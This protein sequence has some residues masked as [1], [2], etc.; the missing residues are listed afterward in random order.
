MA[1]Y[2]EYI[3]KALRILKYQNLIENGQ[4][5]EL[6]GRGENNTDGSENAQQERPSA[7]S[8]PPAKKRRSEEPFTSREIAY[9]DDS[10]KITVELVQEKKLNRFS[11][12]NRLY[13]VKIHTQKSDTAPPLLLSLENAIKAGLIYVI[14]DL[15]SQYDTSEQRQVFFTV[16]EKNILNGLNTGNYSLNHPADVLARQVLNILHSYLKSYETMRLSNSFKINAK[17]LSIKHVDDLERRSKKFKKNIN[18]GVPK[19]KK[20]KRKVKWHFDLSYLDQNNLKNCLLQSLVVAN[21]LNLH[22][23]EKTSKFLLMRKIFRGTPAQQKK[24]LCLINDGASKLANL[25]SIPVIGPHS[26]DEIA[27]KVVTLY[28]CQINLINSATKQFF[29]SYPPKFDATKRQ[30]YFLVTIQNGEVSH[31]DPIENIVTFFNKFG[32]FCKFC[33]KRFSGKNYQHK[34]NFTESCNSCHRPFNQAN[35]YLNKFEKTFYC[36]ARL[37]PQIEKQCAKCN[38]IVKNQDCEKHHLKSVCFRGYLCVSCKH[39]IPFKKVADLDKMVAS[40]ICG[41]KICSFCNQKKF[42]NHL[43]PLSIPNYPTEYTNL[44]F[45]QMESVEKRVS[46]PSDPAHPNLCVLY[47]EKMKRGQFFRQVFADFVVPPNEA[48]IIDVSD[49]LPSELKDLPLSETR[50]EMQFRKSLKRTVAADM[51]ENVGFVDVVSKMLNFILRNDWR[52]RTVL[53]HGGGSFELHL[54]AKAL[55]LAGANPKVLTKAQ[56]IISIE[57][58][59][60]GTRFIDSSCFL[61]SDLFTLS[62]KHQVPYHFFPQKVNLPKLYKY[63]GNCPKMADWLDESDST[64]KRRAKEAFVK[65]LDNVP[66]WCFAQEL[67]K[68]CS[69]KVEI[70]IVSCTQFIDNAKKAQRQLEQYVSSESPAKKTSFLHPFNRPFMTKAAYS[71]TLLKLCC[72]KDLE[73]VKILKNENGVPFRSSKSELEWVAY[74]RHTLGNP[75]D[76][77]WAFSPKG[78]KVCGHK[79]ETIPDFIHQNTIGMFAGCLTHR[80]NRKT[81]RIMQK[82]RQTVIYGKTDEEVL[83]SDTRKLALFF[84]NHPEILTVESQ[85]ECEW[86]KK[87]KGNEEVKHFLQHV[88]LDYPQFRLNPRV[89]GI[90][91][92]KHS[93]TR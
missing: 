91:F 7:D 40:H 39:S 77:V 72:K 46:V 42:D 14:N 59:Q 33:Q 27:D 29:A 38:F 28:G 3:Q 79:Q 17:I 82:K 34:C 25:L 22:L 49:N 18:Y 41:V 36:S 92:F 1:N 90:I 32:Y 73:H 37:N 19:T 48:E 50:W 12:E 54:I 76:F 47:Y 11:L 61:D 21:E 93:Y 15:K 88:Y 71:F 52:N 84:Q 16:C 65:Q 6:I 24:A 89:A 45:L 60:A 35:F 51:F 57:Y 43:C 68:H 26:L 20:L 5:P 53:C 67:L 66:N 83:N 63:Q 10:V 80:H 81:C 4:N 23:E 85:Y 75:E 70:N 9:E 31:A 2:P 74:M 8:P 13:E 58:P 86:L 44:A 55:V 56:K 69:K 87:K 64:K 30:F 62:E 78:Q